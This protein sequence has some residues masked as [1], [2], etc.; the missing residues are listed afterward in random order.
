[1]MSPR[2]GLIP[3]QHMIHSCANDD[4]SLGLKFSPARAGFV[5]LNSI[6]F[7][8]ARQLMMTPR[9]GLIPF[10]HM[11]HNCA[12]DGAPLGLKFSP[13]RAGF[14]NHNL[15]AFPDARQCVSTSLFFFLISRP[16]AF[17]VL[18]HGRLP[19][20]LIFPS[21]RSA[22]PACFC[23]PA[24]LCQ[25]CLQKAHRQSLHPARPAP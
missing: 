5:N 15:I 3:F 1:M 11:I 20:L 10:Q 8:N 13:A 21:V 17:A 25:I 22:I 18:V 7:P 12:N 19:L 4:A 14:V 16:T 6:A 23:L 24:T 2:W 9:W